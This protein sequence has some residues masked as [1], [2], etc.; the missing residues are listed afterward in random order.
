M[1]GLPERAVDQ[2]PRSFSGG[3]VHQLADPGPDPGARNH[4]VVGEH[5]AERL[6]DGHP[7][8]KRAVWVLEHHLHEPALRTSSAGSASP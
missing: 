3:Q 5:L 1:V 7:R 6:P 4:P 8:V 2:L